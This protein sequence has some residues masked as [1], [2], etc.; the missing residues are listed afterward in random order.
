MA[1]QNP[2]TGV[3]A[4]I[5]MTPM[6]DLLLVMLIIF[7]TIAP[8]H[9]KGLPARVPQSAVSARSAAPEQDLVLS[10]ARDGS[11]RLNTRGIQREELPAALAGIFRQRQDHTIFVRGAGELTFG[12]VAEVIDVATAA[13]AQ[14]VALI[15][16]E[17]GAA[18]N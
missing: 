5:N 7:L 9:S 2:T 15:P 13:G 10:V 17:S 6:I 11:I 1:F 16:G 12:Q 14:A 8:V 3:I 18:Q 4:Q